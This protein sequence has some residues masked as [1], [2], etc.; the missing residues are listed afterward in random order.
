[1]CVCLRN[2]DVKCDDDTACLLQVLTLVAMEAPV[3][4]AGEGYSNFVRDAKV[5]VL[6]AM[7]PLKLQDVVLGQYVGN[8]EGAHSTLLTVHSFYIHFIAVITLL[9]VITNILLITV[10]HTYIHTLYNIY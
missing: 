3:K 6:S 2:H 4:V 10:L 9:A 1:V 8:D 5:N 7:S